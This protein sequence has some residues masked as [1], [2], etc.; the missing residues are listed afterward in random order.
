MTPALALGR[1]T[2]LIAPNRSTAQS[3]SAERLAEIVEQIR[4]HLLASYAVRHG[5]EHALEELEATREEASVEG[6]DGYGGKPM[7]P[8]AYLQAKRFLECLPTTAPHPEISADPDGDV[9]LDWLFGPRKALSVSINGAGRCSFACV[10]GLSSLRGTDWFDDGIPGSIA[11]A[12][13]EL[14][15]DTAATSAA[16]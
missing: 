11:N 4:M 16:H 10:R 5:V 15:R 12:L 9:A 3:D 8:E 13:S 1:R 7:N 2:G 6:W 14:A